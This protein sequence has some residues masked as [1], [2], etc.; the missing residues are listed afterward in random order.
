LRRCPRGFPHRNPRLDLHDG[1]RP[2]R[3]IYTGSTVNLNRRAWEH[4]EKVLRGFTR[5]YDVI[6]LV[7]Y[8]PHTSIAKAAHRERQIKRWRRAW[9][10]ELKENPLWRDLF[11]EINEPF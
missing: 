3:H 10:I 2:Q 7:W 6:R 9:K 4:R 1:V 11:D 5:T 8:E